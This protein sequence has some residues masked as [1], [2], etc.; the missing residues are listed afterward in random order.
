M[1][2]RTLS[3]CLVIV[4]FQK[5][6]GWAMIKR[7]VHLHIIHHLHHFGKRPTSRLSRMYNPLNK[8]V[9]RILKIM[10]DVLKNFILILLAFLAPIWFP[11]TWKIFNGEPLINNE[12]LILLL[13]F[14]IPLVLLWWGE[15][16]SK[17]DRVEELT[18]AFKKALKEDREEER[19]EQIKRAGEW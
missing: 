1:T 15:K 7:I 19:K 16:E 4:L 6:G 12:L 3:N 18:K 5:S 11:I 17:K 2:E 9:R 14:I 8:I 10:Y 13:I